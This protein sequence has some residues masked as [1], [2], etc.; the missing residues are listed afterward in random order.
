MSRRGN[1]E[2]WI[3]RWEKKLGVKIPD[4]NAAVLTHGKYK[5]NK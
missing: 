1:Y 4:E 2:N 3:N 5:R